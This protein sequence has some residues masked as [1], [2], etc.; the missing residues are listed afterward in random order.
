MAAGLPGAE[1]GEELKKAHTFIGCVTYL[2][3]QAA[4][5]AAMLPDSG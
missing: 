3:Q 1:E 4:F 5:R 2:S